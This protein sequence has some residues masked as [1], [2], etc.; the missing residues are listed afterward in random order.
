MLP[1]VSGLGAGFPAPSQMI[2]VM[3][4]VEKL[5]KESRARI[6]V[7]RLIRVEF[8]GGDQETLT[9]S[10]CGWAKTQRIGNCNFP[11]DPALAKKLAHYRGKLSDGSPGGIMGECPTCTKKARDERYPKGWSPWTNK[12]AT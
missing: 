2:G 9:C 6:H 8:A 12:K 4:N 3:N 5:R 11:I 10:V 1:A 7:R